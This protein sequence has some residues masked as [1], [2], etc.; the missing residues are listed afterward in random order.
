MEYNSLRGDQIK[1]TNGANLR[2]FINHS[3]LI[4]NLPKPFTPNGTSSVLDLS[5]VLSLCHFATANLNPLFS[6][7]VFHDTTGSD[8]APQI[9]TIKTKEPNRKVKM[10]KTNIATFNDKL[11]LKF[12]ITHEFY[13]PEKYSHCYC[14][15]L[16]SKVCM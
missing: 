15:I 4:L 11:N 3:D 8:H 10:K 12:Y 2:N 7:S 16:N 6:R 5:L 1:N 14:T 9:I 13:I